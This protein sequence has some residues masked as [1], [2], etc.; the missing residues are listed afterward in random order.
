MNLTVPA[1]TLEGIE[2]YETFFHLRVILMHVSETLFISLSTE[3]CKG[4]KVDKLNCHI[5]AEAFARAFPEFYLD[6]KSGSFGLFS[7]FDL[8]SGL[9]W[10]QHSWLV[11]EC[12][13]GWILDVAP[14][15]GV[16]TPLL[17][18]VAKPPWDMLY[19]VDSN[20]P[21]NKTV[22]SESEEI[23]VVYLAD[24]LKSILNNYHTS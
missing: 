22:L 18:C 21:A 23:S 20:L 1:Q 3:R 11:P 17:V 9:V 19:I 5:V 7:G 24:H 16:L 4:I 2:D 15:N 8:E 10:S 12:A 14:Y 6:R 13:P